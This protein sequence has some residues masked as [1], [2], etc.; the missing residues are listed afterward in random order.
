MNT[1]YDSCAE[2]IR[3]YG[4]MMFYVIVPIGKNGAGEV[5]ISGSNQ[6]KLRSADVWCKSVK[7][8]DLPSFYQSV[9]HNQCCQRKQF[10][11]KLIATYCNVQDQNIWKSITMAASRAELLVEFELF[12]RMGPLTGGPASND[13]ATS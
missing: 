5:K 6:L 11:S 8:E 13:W 10:H 3:S 7:A 12:V 9:M 1:M 4:S 2:V